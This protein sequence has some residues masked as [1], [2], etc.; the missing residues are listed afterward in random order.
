MEDYTLQIKTRIEAAV[1]DNYKASAAFTTAYNSLAASINIPKVN[2]YVNQCVGMGISI[3]TA[4]ECWAL[5]I[6]N[7]I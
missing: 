2:T 5:T 4:I 7:G 3:D 1:L 6:I